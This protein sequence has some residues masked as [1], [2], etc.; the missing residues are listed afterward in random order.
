M[1]APRGKV[2]E[3]QPAP[4]AVRLDAEGRRLQLKAA[5]A[6]YRRVIAEANGGVD[7]LPSSRLLAVLTGSSAKP[8]EVKV[9]IS[10]GAGYLIQLVAHQ[11]LDSVADQI[12]KPEGIARVLVV[13]SRALVKTDWVHQHIGFQLEILGRAHQ[14]RPTLSSR[15]SVHSR[16][17]TRK[18]TQPPRISTAMSSRQGPRRKRR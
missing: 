5:K 15:R 1:A 4:P 8:L 13:E 18:P 10:V 9:E 6:K 3:D 16:P 12:E 2:A 17:L 14:N 11:Q 7:D